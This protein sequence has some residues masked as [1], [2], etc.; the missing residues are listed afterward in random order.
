MGLKQTVFA[1]A[2][3]LGSAGLAMAQNT[4]PSTTNGNQTAPYAGTSAN[5]NANATRAGN[6]ALEP[7]ANSFTEG[8]ARRR[9]EDRGYANVGQLHQDQNSIWQAEATKDGHRVRVGVD[10]RG[11]VV[12]EN[13]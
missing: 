4:A 10:F 6:A 7:G 5:P 8:Q 11:N 9:I 2:L 12:E 13:R 1:A 3:L